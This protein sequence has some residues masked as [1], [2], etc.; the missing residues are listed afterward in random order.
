[1][2]DTPSW[3][4]DAYPP[5]PPQPQPPKRQHTARN[6]TLIIV[7]AAVVVAVAVAAVANSGSSSTGAATHPST[8]R[9]A[10]T[11]P[12]ATTA[13]DTPIAE[14]STPAPEPSPDGT[15]EG[16][17]DYEINNATYSDQHA[18]DLDGEVDVENTG[19]IGTVVRVAISWPQLGHSPIVLRKSVRVRAGQ[20]L[21]VPFTR[22][23]SGREI[24][25]LQGWQG[26]HP[27]D[28]GCKVSGTIT[29]TFGS[30]TG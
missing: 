26:G 2:S 15:V 7:G 18:G 30:V 19:N 12:P 13:E 20:T 3:P 6:V 21:T 29:D 1:M 28:D 9:A 10:S 11:T 8:S 23:A 24:D 4:P 27:G 22:V 14:T 25:R 5:P 17:C 16:T